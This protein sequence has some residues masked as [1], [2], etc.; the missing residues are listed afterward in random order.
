MGTT[1][2][3]F[4]YLNE[5]KGLIKEAIKRKGVTV[6]DTDTF[7]SYAEKIDSISQGVPT[8]DVGGKNPVLIK[9]YHEEIP[10]SETNYP[11]ITPT[12]SNQRMYSGIEKFRQQV[13]FDN[14]DYVV[15]HTTQ[16]K[17][18]YKEEIPSNSS[19]IIKTIYTGLWDFY[20]VN[21]DNYTAV[22]SSSA[23]MRSLAMYHRANY[24]DIQYSNS[25][26]IQFANP[27]TAIPSGNTTIKVNTNDI[28]MSINAQYMTADA[29]EKVD[30]EKSTI[31][32]DIKLYQVD[33]GTT[34][35]SVLKKDMVDY[36]LENE[37]N[38]N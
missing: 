12:T 6:E 2:E 10:F 11:N 32:F 21:K 8:L 14:Y 38:S 17:P 28:N 9:K 20:K 34:P 18:V 7:R 30:A 29:W 36:V 1:A 16:V 26:G 31:T 24:S 37:T 3:K 35:A 5:T 25:S 27:S 19:Y 15:K 22:E 23:F 4:N 33:K 13:D